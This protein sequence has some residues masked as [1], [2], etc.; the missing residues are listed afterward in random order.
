MLSDST[1]IA[2]RCCCVLVKAVIVLFEANPE[3]Q[4]NARNTI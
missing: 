3:H 4:H 2:S 1:F